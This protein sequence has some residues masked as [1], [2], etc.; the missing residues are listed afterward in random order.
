MTGDHISTVDSERTIETDMNVM[1][2][3]CCT[4]FHRLSLP[5]SALILLLMVTPLWFTNGMAILLDLRF[6]HHL[7]ERRKFNFFLS[8]RSLSRSTSHHVLSHTLSRLMTLLV[9]RLYGGYTPWLS[10]II[11]IV[12]VW[13]CRL[14]I[15]YDQNNAISTERNPSGTFIHC[16]QLFHLK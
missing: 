8:Y 2:A 16:D 9:M 1:G 3:G 13:W 15:S 12:I 11:I 5:F 14:R 6:D 7:A 10:P 4:R